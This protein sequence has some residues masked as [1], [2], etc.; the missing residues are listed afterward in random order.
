MSE[1]RSFCL[2]LNG[3]SIEFSTGLLH[4]AYNCTCEGLSNRNSGTL[5]NLQDLLVTIILCRKKLFFVFIVCSFSFRDLELHKSVNKCL[6]IRKMENILNMRKESCC[7]F[8]SSSGL[9]RCGK[10]D[11]IEY[12]HG[13]S[14][15]IADLFSVCCHFVFLC[16]WAWLNWIIFCINIFLI[17][18]DK[19][20]NMFERF[21][22]KTKSS[23]ENPITS[24]VCELETQTGRD[25]HVSDPI[26]SVLVGRAQSRSGAPI[27]DITLPVTCE[28]P[29]RKEQQLR[30]LPPLYQTVQ[31]ESPD[32]DHQGR[33]LLYSCM[34][35][36]LWAGEKACPADPH[37]PRFCP[38]PSP[39][40]ALQL[41]ASELRWPRGT[42]LSSTTDPVEPEG[43]HPP[44]RA[45]VMDGRGGKTEEMGDLQNEARWFTVKR[46][47]RTQRG[48]IM[49]DMRVI[50]NGA[51]DHNKDPTKMDGE[52][53]LGTS[54]VQTRLKSQ[55]Q[56]INAH[57]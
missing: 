47:R 6:Y 14:S 4:F 25:P 19:H 40:S 43:L 1:P 56:N 7:L 16:L 42:W 24:S 23:L 30:V 13:R 38:P 48:P 20:R 44:A 12:F 50:L 5:Q 32:L 26:E 41:L 52:G 46:G 53:P 8:R 49:E 33:V 9:W 18:T 31:V 55:Q 21:I 22:K 45:S 54:S 28:S 17:I 34:C 29:H 27:A 57:T 35:F 11:E 10:K 36:T 3:F 37:R 15:E 2:Q 51:W 39:S